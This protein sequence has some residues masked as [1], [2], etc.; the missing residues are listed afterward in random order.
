MKRVIMIRHGNSEANEN[1]DILFEKEDSKVELTDKGYLDAVEA[2]RNLKV[3]LKQNPSEAAATF[4]VSPYTRT[5]QTFRIIATVLNISED[6]A[7]IDHDV[8]EH[9][10]NLKGNQANWEKFMKYKSTEWNVK[11]NADVTFDGGESLNDVRV[12]ARFF[13]KN[14]K[15][16]FAEGDSFGFASGD[17]VLV[18]HGLFIKMVMCELDG[19]E[20][21][22]IHHP[23]NGELVIREI[24]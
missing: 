7:N 22:T 12:R 18:A 24:K 13:I 1:Y 9:F 17:I 14:A 11:D 10:M 4:V 20:P 3:V 2:G 23:A 19:V 15:E 5:M 6:R 8:I 21:D 16:L